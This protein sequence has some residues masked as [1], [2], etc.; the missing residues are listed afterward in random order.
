MTNQIPT[1]TAFTLAAIAD[2]QL[3][4]EEEVADKLQRL[5]NKTTNTT[6]LLHRITQA[7]TT[8][9]VTIHIPFQ[10]ASMHPPISANTHKPRS[11][12]VSAGFSVF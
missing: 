10:V 12:S 9:S 1:N 2:M 11:T 5:E 6:A 7:P 3:Q 8:P 4:I